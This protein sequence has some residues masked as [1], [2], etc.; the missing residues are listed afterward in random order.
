MT[1]DHPILSQFESPRSVP[2]SH[3]NG[4]AWL[5]NDP[6]HRRPVMIKKVVNIGLKGRATDA[7]GLDHPNLV[8]LRRWMVFDGA[9]WL[10]RDVLRGRNLRQH[11]VALGG[12]PDSASLQRIL[13]P[14]FDA[15]AYAHARGVA[16]AGISYENIL[17]ADDGLVQVCDFGCTDPASPVHAPIY[18]GRAVPENDVRALGKLTAA[19]LPTSGP[20]ANP[21]V[22]TRIEGIALRC[23]RLEELQETLSTLESLAFAPVRAAASATPDVVPAEPED[24]DPFRPLEVP[25]TSDIGEQRGYP[26]IAFR[27]V[28]PPMITQ[29][30]G[31]TIAGEVRNT[32]DATLL[33]RMIGTQHPWL[34]VRP[35]ALPLVLA[36]GASA[37]IVLV[38]S[39]ARLAPGD[40]RSDVYLSANA[41]GRQAEAASGWFRHAFEVRARIVRAGGA[42]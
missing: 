7:L 5:A 15:V 22:R 12:R 3:P 26:A 17:I 10:V 13:A 24:N 20:F 27:Q 34:N 11:L 23:T 16:H 2:T 38:V 6:V 39:A 4:E 21:V 33:I 29:G 35:M 9:I 30:S 36:P 32:G 40:Y 8:R 18:G 14:V 1:N 19:L 41:P 28:E 25:S 31:G 42:W 37:K